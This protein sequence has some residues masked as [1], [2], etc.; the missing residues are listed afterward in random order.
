MKPE[1]IKEYLKQIA[2]NVTPETQLE[3]IYEQLALLSDIDESEEQEQK[4]EIFTQAQV[5]EKSK[6]WLK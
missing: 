3:D 5:E 1:K 2:E 6:E 4:G